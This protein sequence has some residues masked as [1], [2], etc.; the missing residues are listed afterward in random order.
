MIEGAS[1]SAE[2]TMAIQ[3]EIAA[4]VEAIRDGNERDCQRV[5][6]TSL[7]HLE[8]A[9]RRERERYEI[10]LP[11]YLTPFFQNETLRNCGED[12]PFIAVT[13]DLSPRGIGFR[14]DEPVPLGH[15]IA[16]FDSQQ[17]G[18]IKLLLEIRWRRRQSL[19]CYLAGARI[20]RVL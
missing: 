4:A 20:E 10:C 7:N 3:Q 14:C 13:R 12:R 11:F 6:G 2:H 16:E 17:T 8:V 18:C 5:T 19:H 15:V 9:D 1:R